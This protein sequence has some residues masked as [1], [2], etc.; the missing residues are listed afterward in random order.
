MTQE[1]AEHEALKMLEF[2]FGNS[3]FSW[4]RFMQ[5][6]VQPARVWWGE[7]DSETKEV[8]LS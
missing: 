2:Y 7:A 8:R 4:D 5:G 1:Q 3:N 6:E